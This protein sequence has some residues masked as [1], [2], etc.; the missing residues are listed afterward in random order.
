MLDKGKWTGEQLAENYSY[1]VGKWGEWE[2]IGAGMGGLSIKYVDIRAALFSGLA[3]TFVTLTVVSLVLSIVLGKIVFPM[4]SKLYTN[5][6]NEMVDM[7]TLK[8]ASQ[9]DEIV[10]TKKSKK[11]WF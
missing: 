7:A 6:N 3:I 11:E 10:S 9:I 4:L 1:L 8:S 2:I 5:N